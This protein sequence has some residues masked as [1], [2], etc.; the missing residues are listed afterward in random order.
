[1]VPAWSRFSVD[2]NTCRTRLPSL[3]MVGKC[4]GQTGARTHSPKPT[5]GQ[6]ATSLWCREPTPS[7]LICRFIIRPD[8]HKVRGS[9]SSP[10]P[11]PVPYAV[12]TTPYTLRLMPYNLQK[13]LILF[14][15]IFLY[16]KIVIRVNIYCKSS[17]SSLSL[18][19]YNSHLNSEHILNPFILSVS[20]TKS[21]SI[22]DHVR[23]WES[24]NQQPSSSNKYTLQL[25]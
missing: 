4:T 10:N 3:C 16:I 13:E 5:S 25:F 15:Y 19:L 11:R 12:H 6:E 22:V 17:H 7:R 14:R 18:S 20:K 21:Q 1:M 9:M 8:N 24:F 2:T 23:D